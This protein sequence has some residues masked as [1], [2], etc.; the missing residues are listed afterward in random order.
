M[1]HLTVA[2]FREL[3]PAFSDPEKYTDDQI[4][5]QIDLLQCAFNPCV[6]GCKMELGEAYWIAHNLLVGSMLET[7]PIG[8]GSYASSKK[9]GDTAVTY[10]QGI[11]EATMKNPYLWTR[12]GQLYK[13]LSDSLPASIGLMIV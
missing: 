1:E 6:W 2:R 12:Y 3:L 13:Q 7:S 8:G 4:Q 9:V 5:A 10:S 11:I